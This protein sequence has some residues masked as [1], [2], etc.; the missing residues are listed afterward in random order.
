MTTHGNDNKSGGR[1]ERRASSPAA[2]EVLPGDLGPSE[3]PGPGDAP[4]PGERRLA[5]E[6]ER[7]GRELVE[8]RRG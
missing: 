5:L 1:H 6:E 4:R 2:G 7:A 3:A 8:R